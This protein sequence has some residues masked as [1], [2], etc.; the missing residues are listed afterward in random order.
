MPNTSALRSL[1]APPEWGGLLSE[2]THRL[3]NDLDALRIDSPA[4]FRAAVSSYLSDVVSPRL[5]EIVRKRP[6][7]FFL[8]PQPEAPHSV[9][10]SLLPD[11]IYRIAYGKDPSSFRIIS[12]D[13]DSFPKGNNPEP[14]RFSYPAVV[15]VRDAVLPRTESFYFAF[16][17]LLS[18]AQAYLEDRYVLLYT[19]NPLSDVF[20]VFQDNSGPAFFT[21]NALFVMFLKGDMTGEGIGSY[22]PTPLSAKQVLNVMNKAFGVHIALESA[23]EISSILL[24]WSRSFARYFDGGRALVQNIPT[25]EAASPYREYNPRYFSSELQHYGKCLSMCRIVGDA[26]SQASIY[27]VYSSRFDTLL[28]VPACM[29]TCGEA[30]AKRFESFMNSGDFDSCRTVVKNAE[31]QFANGRPYAYIRSTHDIGV[32]EAS[33]GYSACSQKPAPRPEDIDFL[34]IKSVTYYR[35]ND[36]DPPPLPERQEYTDGQ[37]EPQ[38]EVESTLLRSYRANEESVLSD[39]IWKLLNGNINL[40]SSKD[41]ERLFHGISRAISESLRKVL[42]DN[43]HT[44]SQSED[45]PTSIQTTAPDNRSVSIANDSA[46]SSDADNVVIAPLSDAPGQENE[47]PDFLPP[48]PEPGDDFPKYPNDGRAYEFLRDHSPFSVYSPHFN[49]NLDKAY[50]TQRELKY[51]DGSLWKGLWNQ[52]GRIKREFGICFSDIFP[53]SKTHKEHKKHQFNHR[54]RKPRPEIANMPM[55]E[56]RKMD[57][58]V[59]A[60]RRLI[61][62]EIHQNK[63]ESE[64]DQSPS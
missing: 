61:V 3:R 37:T 26:N 31:P 49:E 24:L 38:E 45:S 62:K 35:R 50:L 30:I 1:Y 46:K 15:D 10:A 13:A 52:N 57:N 2:E 22:A 34:K 12:P 51:F 25:H 44:A 16:C 47:W 4:S 21:R 5:E 58:L 14:M 48:L 19:N 59:R 20:S 6:R 39:K 8:S 42:Q 17:E 40:A 53:P 11:G 64:S 56:F 9:A 7:Y 63:I 33:A 23:A 18:A 60:K 28:D 43:Q 41:K 27:A 54:K 55:D 29:D 36:V 32:R